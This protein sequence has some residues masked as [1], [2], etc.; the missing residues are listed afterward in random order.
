MAGNEYDRGMLLY[1]ADMSNMTVSV[2]A[3]TP[4][5]TSSHSWFHAQ[6][7]TYALSPGFSLAIHKSAFIFILV[8]NPTFHFVALFCQY[9]RKIEQT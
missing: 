9:L 4:L 7:G 8:L 3:F 1:A 2:A 6:S 5:S